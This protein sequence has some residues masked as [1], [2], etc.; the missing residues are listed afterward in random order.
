M[1]SL[2]YEGQKVVALVDQLQGRFKKGD[3]FTVLSIKKVCCYI[4]IQIFDT[5]ESCTLLCDCGKKEESK[6]L[7]FDQHNFAPIQEIGNMTFE[8][9][10]SMVT[11]KVINEAV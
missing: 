7:Y 6:I 4:C 11:K 10:I 5:E 2:F 1:E 3:K 8:E 9:A